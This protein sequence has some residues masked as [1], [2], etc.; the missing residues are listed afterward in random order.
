MMQGYREAGIQGRRACFDLF[1]RDHP[2]NGGYSIAAGLEEAL[3]FLEGLRFSPEDLAYLDSLG[4]F[5]REFVDAL[6]DFRFTGEIHAAP[7]GTLIFPM[8]P[9]LRI[10]GP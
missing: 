8:E 7:E 10:E 5:T 2:F 4:I 6:R 9:I 3:R 1:F